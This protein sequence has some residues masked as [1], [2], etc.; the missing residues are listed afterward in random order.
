MQARVES[1][2][3]IGWSQ[4]RRRKLVSDD[5]WWIDLDAAAERREHQIV[6]VSESGMN[7]NGLGR[8]FHLTAHE[9]S[10]S[11]ALCLALRW[12]EGVKSGS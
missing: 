8:L 6:R 7:I 11:G 2:A 4:R 1:L 12:A 9:P 3:T 5:F 10:R